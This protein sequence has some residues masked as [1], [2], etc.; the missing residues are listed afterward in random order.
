MPEYLAQWYAN[1]CREYER[2]RDKSIEKRPYRYP[3]TVVPIKG[4]HES[5]ILRIFLTKQ[6]SSTPAAIPEGANIA[7]AIREYAG[8]DPATY[9]Y[10]PEKGVAIL[11]RS[12][13]TRCRYS[14]T[15]YMQKFIGKYERQDRLIEAWMELNNIEYTEKNYLALAKI[16]Q[17]QRK[18]YY[19]HK[20]RKR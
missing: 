19:E 7:I 8:K 1:E 18:S 14:L 11:T 3:E 15:E 9:N 20:K 5:D 13:Q 10:L 12:I 16:Y 2:R 17:R 4:S 6:P